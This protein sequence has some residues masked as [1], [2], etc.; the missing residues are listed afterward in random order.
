MRIAFVDDNLRF[1]IP[2]GIPSVAASLRQAGHDVR[3]F[4]AG[5]GLRGTVDSL[6]ACA[7]DAVA[8]S[9][10]TGGHRTAYAIAAAVKRELGLP[11]VWGGPHPTFFPEM[12]ELPFVDA[13]CVGEGEDAAV[14]F[15]DAFDAAGGRIPERVANFHVKRGGR[16]VRNPV[17]PRILDLERLPRPARE[18]YYRQSPMLFRHGIKHFMAH[19]G[20][21]YACTYCFNHGYNRLYR[22]QAGDTRIVRSR[23]PESIV[24]EILSLRSRV[25][26]RMAAF[27]DDVFTIDREW[28]LRFAEAYAARCRLPFSINARFDNLDPDLVAA[29]ADAGLCLVYAGVEAGNER[30]RNDVMRRRMTEQTM[31]EAADLLRR[32]KVKLLTENILGNPGETFEQACETLEAN[33]RIRPAIANASVFTPYPR[34][35]MTRYA[36][37][38]GWYDGDPQ[39]LDDNY[40]HSSALKFPTGR[41]RS[42]ILNLRC[43]FSLLARH[44]R[45]T[46]LLRPLLDARPNAVFR[47]IGDWLDGY[48]LMACLPYRLSIV[49][50][51]L[52][53]NH[54]LSHYR[55]SARARGDPAAVKSATSAA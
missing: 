15:A 20:C 28:T 49:D 32:H 42:R 3:L 6:R 45:L 47:W 13:V 18:L 38:H 43:F 8:F 37:E 30:I 40:Y 29:L 23:S 26:L 11:T 31:L 51:L 54:Y 25:P 12:I 19:R 27:V 55:R 1:S 4:I 7:P 33:F 35:E 9:I 53:L 39:N 5:G 52:T 10:L 44:P 46:S 41:D 17:R 16:V 48:Y 22:E 50:F 36:V 21:P 2:L 14:E 34:L 24:E